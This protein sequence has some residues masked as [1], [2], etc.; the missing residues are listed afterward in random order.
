MRSLLKCIED[1]ETRGFL[2]F[3][4]LE[5]PEEI[6]S[7]GHGFERDEFTERLLKKSGLNTLDFEDKA[8][9]ERAL[10][11]ALIPNLSEI[12]FSK[13]FTTEALPENCRFEDLMRLIFNE[14]LKKWL[15]RKKSDLY[16]DLGPYLPYMLVSVIFPYAH[17]PQWLLYNEMILNLIFF[18]QL[19][20][21]GKSS[22]L[23][24]ELNQN[25]NKFLKSSGKYIL[26]PKEFGDRL[27]IL[28]V[29]YIIWNE[30]DMIETK[31]NI[32][33]DFSP[34]KLPATTT[35][36]FLKKKLE[37]YQSSG[38]SFIPFASI[39]T[40][41][42]KYGNR[43]V[44]EID[45]MLKLQIEGRQ[46]FAPSLFTS[47]Q[48]EAILKNPQDLDP[49]FAV[50]SSSQYDNG[51]FK[52]NLYHEFIP[53]QPAMMLM[54]DGQKKILHLNHFFPYTTIYP[55]SVIKRQGLSFQEF[56]E[57]NGDNVIFKYQPKISRQGLV[58]DL[59]DL[60]YLWFNGFSLSIYRQLN[61]Q[62]EK[63]FSYIVTE[64]VDESVAQLHRKYFNNF[65]SWIIVKNRFDA[66]L[67]RRVEQRIG[68]LRHD[69]KHYFGS[70]FSNFKS[71]EKYIKNQEDSPEKEKTL[72]YLN[73]CRRNVNIGTMHMAG[74]LCETDAGKSLKF[75]E[76]IGELIQYL[77][78]MDSIAVTY[79]KGNIPDDFEFRFYGDNGI[80]FLA[81]MQN[82]AM[83]A[84]EHGFK[85]NDPDFQLPSQ[86]ELLIEGRL[87]NDELSLLFKNNGKPLDKNNLT[88]NKF[89]SLGYST[90][91]IPSGKGGPQIEKM[92]RLHK[93]EIF[94]A[95][96][97]EW[98]FILGIK[99]QISN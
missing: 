54:Q 95:S 48:I 25:W 51:D 9:F 26:N 43:H 78:D 73:A 89:I 19:K 16:L 92:A 15:N 23:R 45:S 2:A 32:D 4:L 93:G 62:D 88:V 72:R 96:T 7:L 86:P 14:T 30:L 56:D 3:A 57:E 85:E 35:N 59:F 64:T 79:D 68:A 63:S 10:M 69:V 18:N 87:D 11:D 77:P 40:G 60:L 91:E 53:Y 66:E 47:W 24:Q 38:N 58:T 27:F 98:G 39:L 65:G 67:E 75:N 70:L 71:I 80:H 1:K 94:L 50:I 55:G 13:V 61:E 97:P 82:I 5:G 20:D 8:S 36:E 6:D 31:A 99:F 83:N 29:S 49:F 28:A 33:N 41:L 21:E 42:Y 84:K 37:V 34:F 81:L 90:K 76:K 74:T 44:E 12:P 46:S 22:N 17:S 52:V